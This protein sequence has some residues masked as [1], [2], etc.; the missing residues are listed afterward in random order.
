MP[1]ATDGYQSILRRATSKWGETE[2]GAVFG[3]YFVLEAMVSGAEWSIFASRV[4][5]RALL[6]VLTVGAG[7]PPLEGEC[8]RFELF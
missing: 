7:V 5:R 4:E 2:R 1:D 6:I 3:D 8:D